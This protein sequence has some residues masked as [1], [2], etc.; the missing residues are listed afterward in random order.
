MPDFC[1]H[2]VS[3]RERGRASTHTHTHTRKVNTPTGADAIR[4][5]LYDCTQLFLFVVVYVC[6][7][8]FV[9][10]EQHCSRIGDA[11]TA[12]FTAIIGRQLSE[13]KTHFFLS[14][15]LFRLFFS[16]LSFVVVEHVLLSIMF[17]GAQLNSKI[18]C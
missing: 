1:R 7:L 15:P 8:S 13:R 14:R 6:A 16:S 11:T 3:D 10:D 17:V 12:S 4:K 9:P 5:N 2:I 18:C